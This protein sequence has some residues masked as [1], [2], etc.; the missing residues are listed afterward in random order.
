MRNRRKMTIVMMMMMMMPNN[1]CT[2]SNV[3]ESI[4]V[5]RVPYQ[6]TIDMSCS[7]TVVVVLT[8]MM[9]MMV[10]TFCSKEAE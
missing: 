1:V 5:G 10:S 2:I 7:C 3:N 8:T 9:T 4:P 6:I